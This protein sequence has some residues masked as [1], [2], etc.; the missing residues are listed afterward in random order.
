MGVT[1]VLDRLGRNGGIGHSIC[2]DN[3]KPVCTTAMLAL[4]PW[5]C[6]V[7]FGFARPLA[8]VIWRV[9]KQRLRHKCR[10][11]ALPIALRCSVKEILL[12]RKHLASPLSVADEC[13]LKA[14]VG[15]QRAR[16]AASKATSLR[17]TEAPVQ[18]RANPKSRLCH[19]CEREDANNACARA[20]FAGSD[21]LS[22][23]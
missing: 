10:S 7:V 16:T 20:S 12:D 18:H 22:L 19:R 11:I 1:R 13:C 2:S 5:R 6:H 17:I 23:I 15:I 21:G 8:R 3:S 4:P 14:V 9:I